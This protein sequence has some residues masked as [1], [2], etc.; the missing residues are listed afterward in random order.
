MH[1]KSLN[2][3][4]L[5][6]LAK[7]VT[8]CAV[9]LRL[10]GRN[11]FFSLLI[12][13]SV[14]SVTL[15]VKAQGGGAQL[16]AE[17]VTRRKLLK[18][19]RDTYYIS[20][21]AGQYLRILVDQWGMNLCVTVRGPG[22]QV[23]INF[24]CLES[25][26]TPI[27]LISQAAGEFR[28]EIHASDVG[29]AA[30]G[31]EVMID[32]LRPV[33]ARDGDR[34]AADKAFLQAEHL[35]ADDST[36]ALR[37]AI[38]RFEAALLLWGAAGDKRGEADALRGMG[39]AYNALGEPQKALRCYDRARL[40]SQDVKDGRWE[41]GILNGLCASHLHLGNIQKALGYS[42]RALE[43][44]RDAGDKREEIRALNNTGESL[45]SLGETQKSLELYLQALPLSRAIGY[46][47]GEALTLLNFGY[48]YSELGNMLEAINCCSQALAL[49]NALGDRRKQGLTI[50]SMG[51]LYNKL[52]EKQE[53]LDLYKQ[54]RVFFQF[55]GDSVWEASSIAGIGYVYD[56]LGER[57]RALQYSREA[58]A[59]FQ[60]ANQITG[61]AG[62]LHQI[63][64]IYYSLG[65]KQKSLDYFQRSLSTAQA[66]PDPRTIA[67]A[68][69]YMG[70]IY[71]S[72]GNREKALE[73]YNRAL[74]I[75]KGEGNNRWEASTLNNICDVYAGLN[76]KDKAFDCYKKALSLGRSAKDLFIEA[77]ALYNLARVERDRGNLK[78]AR[79]HIELAIGIVETTRAKVAEKD[80]RASYFAT[81][82]RNYEF[83]TDLLMQLHKQDPAA[84]YAAEA[85]YSSERARARNLLESLIEADE[86]LNPKI[87][88]A[89]IERERSLRQLLSEKAEQQSRLLAGRHTARQAAAAAKEINLIT[90]DYRQAQA[91]IR[92]SGSRYIS[93]D[94]LQVLSLEAI[95][96]ILDEGTLLLEYALGD[97]RSYLWAVSSG[98]WRA[99]SCLVARK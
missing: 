93:L 88:P 83:Y 33:L 53:A 52:G 85:L 95:Q 65:D 42:S 99:S 4:A 36:D 82:Q 48:S 74:A 3:F 41:A 24:N 18:D 54:A 75:N 68:L 63:G 58:L 35:R 6:P 5:S 61:V 16:L 46:A 51:H 9:T 57:D 60:K 2:C 40:L 43:L 76:E 91:Q 14:L 73:Y 86:V 7:C 44:S 26:P 45:Y 67:R 47:R 87:A 81:A 17:G 30:G 28:L 96:K 8:C 94:R 27:S 20:L 15:A 22:D 23:P 56:S 50:V 79:A 39:D 90:H 98:S 38:K 84:G 80:L 12:L 78:E 70:I 1:K 72:Q 32:K 69:E 89:L 71:N 19:E 11:I 92:V 29:T 66:I 49:W 25:G 13:T 31:Y 97:D 77:S 55:T 62:T 10:Y 34:I 37:V 59:L 21:N 64:K